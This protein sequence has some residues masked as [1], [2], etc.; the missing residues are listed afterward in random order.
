MPTL[1][2]IEQ[3]DTRRNLDHQVFTLVM[4]GELSYT[5]AQ[6]MTHAQRRTWLQML[7]ERAK[8]QKDEANKA[9]GKKGP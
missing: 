1:N 7:T 2:P 6:I 9:R 5:E 4:D 8:R 3:W